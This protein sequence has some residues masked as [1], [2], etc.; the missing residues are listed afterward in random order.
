MPDLINASEL[1]EF[2]GMEIREVEHDSL[3][4]LLI[5]K[6]SQVICTYCRQE[7]VKA[8]YTETYDGDGESNL[9]LD[10]LPVVSVSSLKIDTIVTAADKYAIRKPEGEIKLIDGSVF[11]KDFENVEITYEAGY[12]SVPEDVKYVCL[13]MCARKFKMIDSGRLGM[14][15]QSFGDQ[16]VSYLN[17]DLTDDLKSM[18]DHFRRR[19]SG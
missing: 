3:L 13:D 8:E 11:T 14:T 15:S 9:L 10:H 4:N 2:L 19:I 17:K 12:A 1:K 7:F 16:S 18:L 6:F 5:T